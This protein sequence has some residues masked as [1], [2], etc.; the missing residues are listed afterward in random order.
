MFN[1]VI[2]YLGVI[3]KK[4]R[5]SI[6][7]TFIYAVDELHTKEQYPMDDVEKYF[8]LWNNSDIAAQLREYNTSNTSID[9]IVAG[10]CE[11][12]KCT[13]HGYEITHFFDLLLLCP[14]TIHRMPIRTGYIGTVYV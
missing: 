5:L 4:I 8:V 12:C 13:Y 2:C 10:M 1:C 3:E 7:C 11:I 14:S 9:S 6:P